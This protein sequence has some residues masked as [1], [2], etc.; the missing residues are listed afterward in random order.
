LNSYFGD[1]DQIMH[2]V[3]IKVK[4]RAQHGPLA[5]LDQTD[6]MAVTIRGAHQ[7]PP[8]SPSPQPSQF[9]N[10][11][12]KLLPFANKVSNIHSYVKQNY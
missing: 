2:L 8:P 9:R 3:R 6:P 5:P 7:S 11:V 10:P 4:S 12:W 1:K